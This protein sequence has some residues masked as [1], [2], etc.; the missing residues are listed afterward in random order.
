MRKWA[1]LGQW[2][3][4]LLVA[5]GIGVEIGTGAHIGFIVITGGSLVFALATKLRRL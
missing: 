3:A 5:A 4:A 2:L 1:W